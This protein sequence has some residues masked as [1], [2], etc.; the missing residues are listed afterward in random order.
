MLQHNAIKN[1]LKTIATDM[2]FVGNTKT[3]LL[4]S[5]VISVQTVNYALHNQSTPFATHMP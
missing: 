3:L 5:T 1:K 2:Q 4:I